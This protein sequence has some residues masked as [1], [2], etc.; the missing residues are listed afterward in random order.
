[1]EI[2]F[3]N[4][5]KLIK[6]IKK[7]TNSDF[8]YKKLPIIKNENVSLT[9]CKK[10]DIL[11]LE[12]ILYD[13]KFICN[14]ICVSKTCSFFS[15]DIN[16]L[17]GMTDLFYKIYENLKKFEKKKIELMINRLK[18]I[19]FSQ[20]GCLENEIENEK[21]DMKEDINIS[22]Y[23]DTKGEGIKIKQAKL[24][25]LNEELSLINNQTSRNNNLKRLSQNYTDTKSFSTL[26]KRIRKFT[27]KIAEKITYNPIQLTSSLFLK[28]DYENG[29]IIDKN[30]RIYKNEQL[31]DIS[32]SDS[33]SSN[34]FSNESFNENKKSKSNI[35]LPKINN[36]NNNNY[37]TISYNNSMNKI[38][39]KNLSIKK[40]A[41]LKLPNKLK[42]NLIEF[43]PIEVPKIRLDDDTKEKMREEEIKNSISFEE[44]NDIETKE[45]YNKIIK[46]ND[47]VTSVLKNTFHNQNILDNKSKI[48]K[49]R[50][51]DN[52]ME[53]FIDGKRNYVY[54]SFNNS[55]FKAKIIPPHFLVR[56]RKIKSNKK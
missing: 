54:Q 20:E 2:P 51:F 43:K 34:S 8:N 12:D 41:V 49:L 25:K 28:F 46:K 5:N 6:F 56:G 27:R 10:G 3:F 39:L 4:V 14:G 29:N 1:M 47:N 42:T 48:N 30:N 38:N 44:P 17:N 11:G 22:S 23:F 32:Y 55:C 21:N 33:N 13:N 53:K 36:T 9:L 15:I 40:I 24:K 18:I 7:L 16:I 52:E 37:N 50:L 26:G 31:N 19:K 35:K 45:F